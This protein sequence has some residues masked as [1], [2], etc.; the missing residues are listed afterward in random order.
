MI[1][2]ENIVS[3][4]FLER[5]NR[6]IALVE[7]SGHIEKAHVM[8]TGRCRELLIP[9]TDIFLQQ[10][11]DPKRKTKYSLITVRK[12]SQ[13]VNLDSQVPNA[14]AAQMA[15]QGY[16]LPEPVFVKREKTYGDSR[17]DI[18]CESGNRKMFIE[19]KGVTLEENGVARFPDAPTERGI[20]HM[21]G[22]INAAADGYETALVFIIQMKGVTSFEANVRT[23]PEFA[24]VLLE[25]KEAG[26]MVKA[27]D[28]IVTENSIAVDSEVPVKYIEV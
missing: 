20:K 1:K 2:Y 12:G 5:P 7:I 25:A 8:N 16:F 22:L 23:Q 11:D 27:F 17:F 6:F 21:R 26:V 28:C 24:R 10:H 15:M 13:L 4:K 18:Y 19:I 9:G 3:A 14:L